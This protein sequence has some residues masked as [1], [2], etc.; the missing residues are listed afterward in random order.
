MVFIY[1]FIGKQGRTLKSFSTGHW[2][3]PCQVEQVPSQ[4]PSTPDVVHL[5]QMCNTEPA[6]AVS[7]IKYSAHFQAVFKTY[8]YKGKETTH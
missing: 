5:L 7:F 8:K 6:H 2:G 1:N 3:W 4:R